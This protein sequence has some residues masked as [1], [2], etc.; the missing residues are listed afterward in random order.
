MEWGTAG[1]AERIAFLRTSVPLSA[2]PAETLAVLADALVGRPFVAGERLITQGDRGDSM[3][4]LARGE[5]EVSFVDGD[6]C[7]RTLDR[8][9]PPTVLGEMA[10]ITNEPRSADVIAVSDGAALVLSA[11]EFHRIVAAHP[12]VA[13]VLTYI[14]ADRIGGVERDGLHGKELC[15]YRIRRRLGLGATAV[16]YQ[17]ERVSDGER[18]ALKMMS[19]WLAFDDEAAAALER[20][21][22]VMSRLSHAGVPRVY[23]RFRAFATWFVAMEFCDGRD[24]DEILHARG[25]LP[26]P[27]ARAIVGQVAS[28]LMHV[29]AHGVVHRDLKPSNVMVNG[30][31][32]VKLID[33]GVA[34]P[35]AEL[36]GASTAASRVSGTPRYMAPEQFRTPHVGPAADVYALGCVAYELLTGE[37]PFVSDAIGDLVRQK[38]SGALPSIRERVPGVGEEL[39]G[40][41][42]AAL[43][44]ETERRPADLRT[45]A[46]W[47][48]PAAL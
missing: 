19:H 47:A 6:G 24:L 31:G 7:V 46:A 43:S 29:H 38:L 18:V 10:L 26:P 39:A 42:D 34:I 25:G 13:V 40:F 41:V 21:V 2:L 37:P 28:A 9:G 17:A 5:V 48:A 8:C 15:G 12:G 23:E 45:A 4:V 3:V 30:D 16:V 27:Q 14:V 35:P 20:E 44:S 1:R 22:D 33:F 32:V 11:E 36:S